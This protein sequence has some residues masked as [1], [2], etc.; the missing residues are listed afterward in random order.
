MSEVKES[1]TN[2]LR[3]VADDHEESGAEYTA[4]DYRDAARRIDDLVGKLWLASKRLEAESL[5]LLEAFKRE[6][7]S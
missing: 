6:A 4:K 5:N 1:F 2:Y 3:R 7:K